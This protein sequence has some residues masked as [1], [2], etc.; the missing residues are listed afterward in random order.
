MFNKLIRAW[1]T[2]FIIDVLL[3]IKEEYI[4]TYSTY[5][6]NEKC[7][8]DLDFRT[9]I[10]IQCVDS[11]NKMKFGFFHYLLNQVFLKTPFCF[12]YVCSDLYTLAF[13]DTR[14][15]LIIIIT[16]PFVLKKMYKSLFTIKY[17][18]VQRRLEQ[19]QL[20]LNNKMR[21]GEE[22]EY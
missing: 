16:S 10:K 4:S 15:L 8:N 3:T 21:E 14:A 17:N 18:I 6:L 1:F 11:A 5:W 9:N 7:N 13:T 19:K 22:E 20:V 2:I 12:H